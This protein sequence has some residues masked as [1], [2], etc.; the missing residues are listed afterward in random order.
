MMKMRC[1]TI[2]IVAHTFMTRH[3]SAGGQPPLAHGRRS[4]LGLAFNVVHCLLNEESEIPRNRDQ[5]N[6]IDRSDRGCWIRDRDFNATVSLLMNDD[7]AKQDRTD[8]LIGPDRSVSQLRIVRADD[9][10][11]TEI[12]CE[13]FLQSLSH[14][15]FRED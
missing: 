14:V 6:V 3:A 12:D 2:V 7:V 15:D 13:M 11:G 9:E 10:I 8:L 4:R 1:A 5:L